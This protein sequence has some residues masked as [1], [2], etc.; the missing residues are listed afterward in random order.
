MSM[1]AA[2]HGAPYRVHLV[3]CPVQIAEE[4][5]RTLIDAGITVL[6]DD[7]KESAG[8]KFADADLIGLPIRI[9]LG[10]RSLKEGKVEVKVRSNLDEQLSFDLATLVDKVK[11][12]IKRLENQITD[13]MHLEKWKPEK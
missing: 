2:D 9:T 3:G 7:L 11:V 13:S 12:L 1:G 10:N 8:V 6:Y 5:Y 4:I